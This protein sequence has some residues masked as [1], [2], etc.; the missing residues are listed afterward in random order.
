MPIQKCHVLR[1]KGDGAPKKAVRKA[2]FS[3]F[4]LELKSL[5]F[6]SP[7][8]SPNNKRTNEAHDDARRVTT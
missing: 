1:Q 6:F 7:A 8:I 4:F 2:S 5:F 3:S